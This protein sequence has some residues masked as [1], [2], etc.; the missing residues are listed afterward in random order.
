MTGCSEAG[1]TRRDSGFAHVIS[2]QLWLH[3]EDLY[4][5]RKVLVRQ[6]EVDEVPAASEGLLS[7][8]GC[9]GRKSQFS[10]D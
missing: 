5:A 4:Q 10:S 3:A 2:Q 6:R 8:D 7:V 9:W 1:F